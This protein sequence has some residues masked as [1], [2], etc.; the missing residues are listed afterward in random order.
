MV[1]R[2]KHS[3]DETCP[4]C[5]GVIVAATQDGI[6]MKRCTCEEER[7]DEFEEMMEAKATQNASKWTKQFQKMIIDQCKQCEYC[8]SGV[9]KPCSKPKVINGEG[10]EV[11]QICGMHKRI[12]NARDLLCQSQIAWFNLCFF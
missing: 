7:P 4:K 8:G 1:P 9:D 11:E 10:V 5:K 12:A 6:L 3:Q 2:P